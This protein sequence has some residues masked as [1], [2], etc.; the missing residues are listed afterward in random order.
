MS[1]HKNSRGLGLGARLVRVV[2]EH[3]RLVG[4]RRVVLST[5]TVMDLARVLYESCGFEKTNWAG[6]GATWNF[7][8]K[9]A[10]ASATLALPAL[11]PAAASIAVVTFASISCRIAAPTHRQTEYV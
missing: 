8:L 2:E 5:Y 3:A 7:N 11:S 9:G 1:V 10:A 4:A 6:R